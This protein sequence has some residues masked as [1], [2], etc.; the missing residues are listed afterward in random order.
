MEIRKILESEKE[1]FIKGTQEAFQYGYE[2]YFGKCEDTI[3]PR[4]DIISSFN[5]QGSQ[6]YVAIENNEIIGG[7]IVV[8]NEETQI[9][10]LHILYV[11]VGSQSKGIG[12]KLWNEMEKIYSKTKIWHTCTPYFDERNVHFYVNKCHF[13]IVEFFNKYHPDPNMSEYFIGDAGEGMF[14]FE[15]VMK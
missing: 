1:E 6:T 8:I 14:H 11:K 9:N 15:K 4:Q 5:C 2:R 13:H 12:L 3:I 10:D 7:V